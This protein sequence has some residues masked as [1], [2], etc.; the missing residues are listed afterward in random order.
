MA[1]ELLE[2]NARKA[3]RAIF[4]EAGPENLQAIAQGIQAVI[5]PYCIE[6]S[7]WCRTNYPAIGDR[8][9]GPDRANAA[10]VAA[11]TA[12][13][14]VPRRRNCRRVRVIEPPYRGSTTSQEYSS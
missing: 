11:A 13:I 14:T 8:K 10:G 1:E 12:T 7:E 5:M 4:F 9:R 2:W 3:R 6:C